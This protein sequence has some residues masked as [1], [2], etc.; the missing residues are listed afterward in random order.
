MKKILIPILVLI[1]LLAILCLKISVNEFF[2]ISVNEELMNKAVSE[3]NKMC[4]N[5]NFS[6]DDLNK[7]ESVKNSLKKIV[8]DYRN[9]L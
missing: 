3:I 8:L 5:K 2:T 1:L 6:A 9:N 4:P 7:P